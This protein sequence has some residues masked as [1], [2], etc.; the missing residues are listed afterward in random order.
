MATKKDKLLEEAQRMALRGQLDK[1]IRLYE[2]VVQ[3]EPS[4]INHRQKLAELLVKAGYTEEARTEFETIGKHYSSNA[5]YLK[6]IAVYKK[7]Q[8]MFPKD[9][10]ITLILADL[11]EKHG[12]IANALAEYKQV[13]DY[14]E[15]A[16]NKVD[17]IKILEKMLAVDKQNFNIKL[18]L[19]EAYFQAGRKSDSYTAF[20]GIA[21]MLQDR[22]DSTA[23]NDINSRIQQMFPEKTE[24]LFEMLTEQV[25]GGKYASAVTGLEALL[26]ANSGEKRIWDLLIKAYRQMDRPQDVKLACQRYLSALPAALSAREELLRCLIDE[27]DI[28]GALAQFYQYEQDLIAGLPADDL[29]AL[30]RALLALDPVNLRI[31]EGLKHAC[32]LSGDREN[33]DDAA[34]R[35]MSLQPL[36]RAHALSQPEEPF[37][38]LIDEPDPLAGEPP[39]LAE[40]DSEPTDKIHSDDLAGLSVITA[41][42]PGLTCLDADAACFDT[43]EPLDDFI[44][45]EIEIEI[46]IDDDNGLDGVTA[47]GRHE[48]FA[49]D[50]LDPFGDISVNLTASPRSVKFGSNLEL[51][52]A[53]SHY[54]LGVA[55]KE[56]GLY[57][58][59]VNEFRQAMIDPVRRIA[60]L[61][62]QGACLRENG[63]IAAAEN[64]L[65]TVLKPG[66]GLEDAC[67]ARYELALTLQASGKN[68]EAAGL[69]AEIDVSNPGFRDA[70]AC[71]EDT[72]RN[73]ELDFS[74]EDLQGFD[75]K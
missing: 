10:S 53:Q 29:V 66:L 43:V 25:S 23:L 20:G 54:D 17:A 38:G 50:W 61:I 9:I 57:G 36:S 19:A 56:M 30:Y 74:D 68:D 64:I 24:F 55:F 62:L 71:Q 5:F 8:T 26:L 37:Q 60:C 13:Y 58:E 6:A 46:E 34:A 52:D 28:K 11:N 7:L 39:V 45:D 48:T 4:A 1:A 63:D 15:K 44:E 65:R 42:L 18:K 51:S 21:A 27:K 70:H 69:L 12:L 41:G 72:D 33:A 32:E 67:S 3:L 59:A 2:Q 14:Y 31:L 47:E 75:L 16:S 73:S 40:S 35:I 22:G 49:D